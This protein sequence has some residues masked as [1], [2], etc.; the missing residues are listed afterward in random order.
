MREGKGLDYKA[1]GV[2]IDATDRLEDGYFRM[3]G[4]TIVP[5]AIRNDGGYGGLFRLQGA[6]GRTG[7][8]WR[9]PV[10]VSGTDGVGT[11]LKIAFATG[12]HDTVGIDLVAMSVNDILVQG[13]TPLFF[14]DYIGIGKAEGKT[15]LAIVKGVAEGCRQAGCALLGGETAE[16]PGFYARGEYDLAG[17]AVGAVERRRLLDGSR[18][19]AG[20]VLVGLPSSGLHSNGYS[21]ARKALLERAGLKLGRKIPSLGRT[22][23]EELLC[24]TRIYVKPVLKLIEAFKRTNPVHA[25]AHITGGGIGGNL[26]RVIPAGRDAVINRDAW[27]VPPIFQ[28]IREAGGIK[29]EEMF[30][31][32]NMGLGMIAAAAPESV[33]KILK[34][35]SAAGC[36]GYVVGRIVRGTGKVIM[37]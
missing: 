3:I 9:D 31:V 12:R 1:A 22:L 2:D 34:I 28:L 15:L 35:L 27:P 33:E 30:R 19:E 17:F 18:V 8:R 32:F 29:P 16:L 36:P 25:L 26:P 14:L 7:G 13:A 5:G 21:L 37:A 20:D 11:K 10:L 24:P 23:G 4:S 6:S